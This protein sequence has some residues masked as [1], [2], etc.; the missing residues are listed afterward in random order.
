[1]RHATRWRG[2]S[3]RTGGSAGSGVRTAGRVDPN[4]NLSN[5]RPPTGYEGCRV[6]PGAMPRPAGAAMEKG[7][8]VMQGFWRDIRHAA[9]GLR[10]SPGFTLVVVLTLALGI[11][12]NT[13][14]FSLTDQVLLRSLPVQATRAAR[15]PRRSRRVPGAHVQ[16]PDVLLPDVLATSATGTRCSTACSR[17][18]RPPLTLH[19]ERPVRARQRRARH[20]QL[21]RRAR[22]PRADRPRVQR[23]PTIA[24]PGGHPVAV[25][26]H[27]YWQRRFAG[28]PAVL[29][30]TITLNGHA[31]DDR[32]RQRRRA[33]A[34]SQVGESPDVM[35]PV[36]MKAQMTPTWDDLDNRRSRWLTV[37]ARLKPGVS[38]E[39]AEAADERRST[40]RSTS[41][42]SRRSRRRRDRSAQRFVTQASDAAAGRTR[43]V[44]S[45]QRSSRRRSSC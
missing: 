31:D 6:I 26:S 4:P 37:M 30:Q 1:M 27:G 42:R 22:R 32:R 7:Q 17:G 18:F 43:P 35:V 12:A 2:A 10:K 14:I 20:R 33:S 19:G 13:A 23:R 34:A 16:Q 41:R 44:G 15:R 45:A 21:L 36:M 9:R 5:R 11:G 8:H 3:D 40:A 38:R 25:L 28:D 24:T 29:N 39:Q